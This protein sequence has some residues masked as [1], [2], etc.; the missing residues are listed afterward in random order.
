MLAVLF[1]SDPAETASEPATHILW[2]YSGS[3]S[4][5]G[6]V[7]RTACGISNGLFIEGRILGTKLCEPARCQLLLFAGGALA[8]YLPPGKSRALSNVSGTCT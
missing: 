6:A 8:R 4:G 7:S 5:F 2:Q 1:A 3:C